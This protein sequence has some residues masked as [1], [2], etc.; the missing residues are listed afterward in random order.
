MCVCGRAC[1]CAHVC[2]CVCV[3]VFVCMLVCVCVC[4][5]VSTSTV[6]GERKQVKQFF[7]DT[8]STAH[9]VV[10]QCSH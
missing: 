9:P 7:I 6:A 10:S 1:M 8:A 4:I 5:L 2:V 3:R